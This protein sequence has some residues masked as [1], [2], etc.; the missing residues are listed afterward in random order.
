MALE[1]LR[2]ALGGDRVAIKRL[3]DAFAER[4]GV[5]VEPAD[6]RLARQRAARLA[7]HGISLVIDVGA[8]TG[9]YG[10]ALRRS[11]Y[12][13]RIVS[14]EPQP[15][16]RALLERSA[17]S[18]PPWEVHGCALAD[19]RG[20]AEL[21][22]TVDSQSSSLLRPSAPFAFMAT[23]GTI[24]VP[25]RTLDE[26]ELARAGSHVLLKLDVQGYE[27]A[28]LRGAARTLRAT[29]LV[30]CELSLAPLYDGQALAEEVMAELRRAG[31]TPVW[32]E[33]GFTDRST[34]SVIQFDVLFERVPGP[35]PGE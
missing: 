15:R 34:G 3:V 12:R 18:S 11:G 16:A 31:F 25:L 1:H 13:G 20:E 35:R 14:F 4:L 24:T 33:R 7:D 27:L 28:V 19:R 8:N 5:H 21:T 6:R 26:F 10:S 2:A 32:L 23:T 22:V 29:D 9:Q 17:A 30:E